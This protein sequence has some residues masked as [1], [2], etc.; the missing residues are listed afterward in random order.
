M[1]TAT[2]IINSETK[3]QQYNRYNND[4]VI[5]DFNNKIAEMHALQPKRIIAYE[6]GAVVEQGTDEAFFV[7]IESLKERRDDYIRKEYPALVPE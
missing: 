7:A 5:K 1:K 2:E 3:E 6:D 4:P